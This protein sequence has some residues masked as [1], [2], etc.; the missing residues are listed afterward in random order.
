MRALYVPQSLVCVALV[1]W[2]I[3]HGHADEPDDVLYRQRGILTFRVS[4]PQSWSLTEVIH[5]DL[6][7]E[8]DCS[9]ILE[10]LAKDCPNVRSI[11]LG[12]KHFDLSLIEAARQFPNLKLLVL[13]SV[14]AGDVAEATKKWPDMEF[15]ESQRS[16]IAVV[17]KARPRGLLRDDEDIVVERRKVPNGFPEIE[18]IHAEYVIGLT[19]QLRL[20]VFTSP[21]SKAILDQIPYLT[22]L[23]ELDLSESDVDDNAL[24]MILPPLRLERLVLRET[25]IKGSGLKHAHSDRLRSL[26]LSRTAFSGD[27]LADFTGLEA[28]DLRYSEFSDK[29]VDSLRNL[30]TLRRLVISKTKVTSEG[31]H[32]LGML[33]GLESIVIDDSLMDSNGVEK[34]RSENEKLTINFN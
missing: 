21:I 13:D 22:T 2:M 32:R 5:L 23:R 8:A 10:S 34:L 18:R 24:E 14:A 28:L 26:D 15:W 1:A 11:V 27:W 33:K 12:G 25:N 19:R 20:P 17:R 4:T 6:A 30:Q 7:N 31:I 3:S 9:L 29:D 16:A